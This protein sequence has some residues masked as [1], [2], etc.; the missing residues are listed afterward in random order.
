MK[1]ID[2]L[3]REVILEVIKENEIH[4][5]CKIEDN[6]SF[7]DDLGIDSLN[8]IHLVVKVEDKFNVDMFSEGK[9]STVKELIDFIKKKKNV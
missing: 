3:I 7:N 4:Y 2:N 1:E 6:Y 9:I 5:S 8:M